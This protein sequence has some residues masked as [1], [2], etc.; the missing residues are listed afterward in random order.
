MKTQSKS[1]NLQRS[2]K[3]LRNLNESLKMTERNEEYSILGIFHMVS[4]KMRSKTSLLNSDL[5]LDIESLDPRK[6]E[7]QKGIVSLNLMTKK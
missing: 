1:K 4:M 2:L 6:Q 5:S 7:D 3:D